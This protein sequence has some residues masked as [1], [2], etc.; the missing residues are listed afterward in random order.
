[1]ATGDRDCDKQND[2]PRAKPFGKWKP[3]PGPP[4]TTAPEPALISPTEPAGGGQPNVGWPM[5]V[6]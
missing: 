4:G 6:T 2:A 3:G 1:M 5:R